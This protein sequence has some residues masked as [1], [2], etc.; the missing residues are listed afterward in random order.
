MITESMQAVLEKLMDEGK[1]ES[2]MKYDL[3]PSDCQGN[4]YDIALTHRVDES[5]DYR[6]GSHLCRVTCSVR[7]GSRNW[8]DGIPVGYKLECDPSA[9]YTLKPGEKAVVVHRAGH[10]IG[11]GFMHRRLASIAIKS[12]E[13]AEKRARKQGREPK[14]WDSGYVYQGRTPYWIASTNV[15]AAH[16]SSGMNKADTKAYNQE[17]SRL[18][19][20]AAQINATS[21][22]L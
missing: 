5:G 2:G 9:P 14:P 1:I 4:G 17:V 11:D 16:F 6:V 12:K 15:Y 18:E 22:D 8:H 21:P 10:K 20:I 19:A 13:L 3:M 7:V